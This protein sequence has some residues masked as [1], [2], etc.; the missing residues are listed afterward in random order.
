[1]ITSPIFILAMIT[2]LGGIA[3]GLWQYTRTKKAQ[4]RRD[5]Q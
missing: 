4:I 2:L 1:M 3:F 5:K